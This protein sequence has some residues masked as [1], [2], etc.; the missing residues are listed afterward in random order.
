[1]IRSEKTEKAPSPARHL[2]PPEESM[3]TIIYIV[4]LVVVI[5]FVLSYFGFR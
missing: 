5:G 2:P 4:G 3:N 1:M